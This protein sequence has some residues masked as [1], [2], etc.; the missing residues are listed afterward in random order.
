MAGVPTQSVGTRG[1]HNAVE[2]NAGR[3]PPCPING[4]NKTAIRRIAG[5]TSTTNTPGKMKKIRGSMIL[6]EVLAARSSA[7]WRRLQTHGVGLNAQSRGDA[8]A[9]LFGLDD[10]GGERSHVVDSG[11]DAQVAQH[12]A[13]RPAHLELEVGDGELFADHRARMG[14]LA[15]DPAHGRVE[16]QAGLD[17]DDHQ[18]ERVGKAQEDRLAAPFLAVADDEVGQDRTPM[19]P[20]H[21]VMM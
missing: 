2:S 16:P 14:Q 13:P 5:P 12:V 7:S 18:V 6:T 15:G 21:A 10:H 9:E 17:A 1:L 19:P 8:R 4:E 3:Q 11:A 20:A